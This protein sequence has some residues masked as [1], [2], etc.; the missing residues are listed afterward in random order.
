VAQKQISRKRKADSQAATRKWKGKDWFAI[1][2]PKMFNE[3]FITETPTTDPKTLM[4]RNLEVNVSD[5]LKQPQK[6]YMKLVFKIDNIDDKEK[7]VYTRFN[8]YFVSKE[9]VYRVVRKRIQKVESVIYVETSD[10][11]KLQISS[12]VILNR[13][14]ESEVQRKVRKHVESFI[15]EQASKLSID[16]FVK[17]VVNGV[18]QMKIKKSGTKIYPVRFS[19]ITKIEV[20]R[21]PS[22]G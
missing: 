11:W 12:I 15:K 1:L 6:Y 4:G 16:D 21:V 5:L 7:R 20:K 10:K 3:N 14:T 22:A 18:L 9:H 13:N 17:L 8:G 2:T 19:E